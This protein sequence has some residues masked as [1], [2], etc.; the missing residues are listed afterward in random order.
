MSRRPSVPF[1]RASGEDDLV[2]GP[3]AD[4]GHGIGRDIAGVRNTPRPA[5]TDLAPRERP[6]EIRRSK[7][8]TWRVAVVA[9]NDRDQIGAV[10]RGGNGIRDGGGR[11]RALLLRRARARSGGERVQGEHERGVSDEAIPDRHGDSP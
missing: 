11:G 8:R 3:C 9:T 10:R 2:L 7:E 4:A 6:L 1:R 5:P